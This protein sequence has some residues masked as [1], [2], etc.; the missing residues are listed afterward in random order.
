MRD[1]WLSPIWRDLG[2]CLVRAGIATPEQA[3]ALAEEFMEQARRERD[4]MEAYW[5]KVASKRKWWHFV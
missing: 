2:G 1:V 4:H 3:E 5:A